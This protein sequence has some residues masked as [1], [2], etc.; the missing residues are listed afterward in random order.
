[1]NHKFTT[2]RKSLIA[3]LVWNYFSLFMMAIVYWPAWLIWLNLLLF[4]LYIIVTDPYQG[5]L[6][7]LV[8][9]PAYVALPNDRFQTL[10]TWRILFVVLFVV[11]WFKQPAALGPWYSYRRALAL[12]KSLPRLAWDYILAVYAAVIIVV[13]VLFAHSVGTGLR[14]L[15][16]FIN[17][18][19]IYLVALGTIKTKQQFVEVLKFGAIGFSLLIAVGY[20][21]LF[22]TFFTSLDTFWVYWASYLTKLYYGQSFASVALYSNSWFSYNGARELR[23]FSIMPDSQSFAYMCVFALGWGAALLGAISKKA[24]YYLWSGI[25]FAGLSVMLAG[26]RAVWVGIAAP[27]AITIWAYMKKLYTQLAKKML[28]I[29]AIILLFFVLSPLFNTAFN[30]LQ[31]SRFKE[32]FWARAESIYN[33]EDISNAGRLYIWRQSLVYWVHHP[34]GIGL[35]NFR[36]ALPPDASKRYNL[37]EQ[38]ISAHNLYLQILV[39]LGIVG[40]AVFVWFWYSY[41]RATIRFLWQ[42]RQNADF[43]VS[44]VFIANLIFSWLLLAAFFDITWLND[45][46][47]ILFF[48]TLALVGVVVGRYE[49]LKESE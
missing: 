36:Q 18:Y 25:R 19:L 29:F 35:E 12:L 10:A 39:E 43:L 26:T 9:F 13:T 16:F 28:W 37:P 17:A 23:M 8:S 27:V 5:L 45:K 20:V 40:L 33:P 49:E 11:W 3:L 46:V 21:Q 24:R 47:L 41:F 4:V 38:Y 34:L 44:Y 30:Y 32:N 1:M 6:L 42:H 48:F 14:E 31:F 22:S 2:A 15:V 7:C